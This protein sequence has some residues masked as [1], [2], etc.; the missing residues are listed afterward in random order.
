MRGGKQDSKFALTKIEAE[1][2]LDHYIIPVG[3]FLTRGYVARSRSIQAQRPSLDTYGES[4]IT[5]KREGG[6][7]N[8]WSASIPIRELPDWRAMHGADELR[9]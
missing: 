3:C 2:T 8:A 7:H 4:A 9:D 5:Q 1:Q 6:P